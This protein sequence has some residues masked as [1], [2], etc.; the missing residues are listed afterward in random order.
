MNTVR[1]ENSRVFARPSAVQ[2]LIEVKRT[3]KTHPADFFITSMFGLLISL[4]KIND[5]RGNPRRLAHLRD[6]NFSI[7]LA[8]PVLLFNCFQTCR[9]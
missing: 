7:T 4:E 9:H 8:T 5:T 3:I 2:T 6:K 1:K